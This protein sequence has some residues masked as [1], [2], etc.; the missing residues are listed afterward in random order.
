MAGKLNCR[1]LCVDLTRQS[2]PA[3]RWLLR[4]EIASKIFSTAPG[5]RLL[6]SWLFKPH[7]LLLG[8]RPVAVC[9]GLRRLA[10]NHR[11]TGQAIINCR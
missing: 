10:R 5:L 6:L 8:G 7:T 2:L 9:P 3:Y 4:A 1:P 11:S